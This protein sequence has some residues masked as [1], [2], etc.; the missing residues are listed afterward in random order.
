MWQYNYSPENNDYLAHSELM[1]FGVPGMK[2]GVRKSSYTPKTALGY[3]HRLNRLDQKSANAIGSYIRNDVKYRKYLSK[4]KSTNNVSKQK[5]LRVKKIKAYSK[6]KEND[7]T[8]KR[9]T[10]ETLKTIKKAQSNGLDVTIYPKKRAASTKRTTA[11]Y[12]IG[13]LPGGA[14]YTAV[15]QA[16]YSKVAKNYAGQTPY[17]VN[18]HK[19]KVHKKKSK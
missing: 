17:V 14:L 4:M 2:W 16:R 18:G 9:N 3:K 13:G 10:K 11:A 15:D 1:H 5:R 8:V 6:K 7:K 12:V 19:F